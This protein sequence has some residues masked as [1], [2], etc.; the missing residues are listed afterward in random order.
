M[1]LLWTAHA[2][3]EYEYWQRSDPTMV[4]KIN[5]LLR[6]T[7]RSPFQGLGKPEPLK[8]DLTG[9]WSRRILGEHRLVYRVSGKGS[10]Q[11]LEIIQCRFHYQK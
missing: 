11:Q 5:N 1:N 3:E 7:K 8:G 6:D 2:W 10:V 9:F 4:E